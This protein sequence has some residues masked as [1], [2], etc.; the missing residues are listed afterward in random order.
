VGSKLY[1]QNVAS[2]LPMGYVPATNE[3]AVGTA[4]A[5]WEELKR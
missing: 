4:A 5:A 1:Q 3:E 2:D